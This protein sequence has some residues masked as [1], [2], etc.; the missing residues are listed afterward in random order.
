MKFPRMA[1]I[2]SQ[3]ETGKHKN[4][5]WP[6]TKMFRPMNQPESIF[7]SSLVFR[8]IEIFQKQKLVTDVDAD[9]DAMLSADTRSNFEFRSKFSIQLISCFKD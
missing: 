2:W 7:V 9:A 3:L 4:L 1:L 8:S 6:N 5:V